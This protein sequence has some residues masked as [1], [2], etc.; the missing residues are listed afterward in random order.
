MIAIDTNNSKHHTH[1]YNRSLF[2]YATFCYYPFAINLHVYTINYHHYTI[3]IKY[4]HS[5]YTYCDRF[6]FH[7]PCSS[8]SVDTGVFCFVHSP[9]QFKFAVIFLKLQPT[10]HIHY[11]QFSS[12]R[13]FSSRVIIFFF[14]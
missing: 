6:S 1:K 8:I 4:V 2:C 7:S 13:S 11:T 14:Q 5:K 9:C 12:F 10:A 3:H